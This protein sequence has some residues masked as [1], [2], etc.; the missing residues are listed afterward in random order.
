MPL[1]HEVHVIS[2]QQQISL[3]LLEL[4]LYKQTKRLFIS[5][6]DRSVWALSELPP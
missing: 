1:C 4:A 5:P 2:S 3:E 6:H